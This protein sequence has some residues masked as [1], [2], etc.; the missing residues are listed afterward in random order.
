MPATAIEDRNDSNGGGTVSV[1]RRK[2]SRARPMYFPKTAPCSH[3]CPNHIDIR[4]VLTTMSERD[5]DGR[6]VDESLEAAWRIYT[7]KS[8]FPAI[9]GRV[10][11]HPCEDECNRAQRDESVGI[12]NV[13]RFIGDY[14]IEKGLEFDRIT[15]ESRAEKIAV[16]GSGP[17]G[18]SCAYQLTRRGY[19]VTVYEALDQPGGM[20][21]YGIPCY[22]LSREVLDAEYGRLQ[23]FGIEIKCSAGVGKE[24][25]HEDLI[26]QYNSI[27]LGIGAHNGRRLAIPGE[28]LSNI[29]TGVDF[30]NRINRGEKIDVGGQVVVIGGGNTA[31]D[32]ARVSRRLGAKSTILYR[33][34]RAE[35]PAIA[36]EIIYA[37][38]EGVELRLLA[39]PVE[40]VEEADTEVTLKCI[41][42]ELGEPDSSGRRRPIP[43][44]GSYFHLRASTVIAAISQEPE[45]DGFWGLLYGRDWI[46]INDNG[47]TSFEK[48]YAG[49]DVSRIGLA[50]DAVYQGRMAA[51]SI[52]AKL[53]GT[54]VFG[55]DVLPVI[56]AEEMTLSYYPEKPRNHSAAIPVEERL[57][58][59]ETE[60][61][62]TISGEQALDEVDRCMSCGYCSRCGRCEEVCE[63]G[64][65]I[66]PKEAGEYYRFKIENCNG[67]EE[68][69]RECP[70][71]FIEMREERSNYKW[72][73][74]LTQVGIGVFLTNG[75]FKV[76]WT[77]EIYD[78]PLKS[79]CVP[80]LNCHACPMAQLSCPI[81]MI[82]YYAAVHQ[83][84]Y[85]VLGFLALIGI[86]FGRAACG[87][88][89]P[90][91]WFQDMMYKIKTRKFGIPKF[92]YP[93]KWVILPVLVIALPYITGAHWFSKLCP[94]GALIGGIPWAVWNPTHPVFEE[95]IIEP[96]SFGLMFWVKIV[97]LGG[98]L[99]WFVLA[100]RPF[101]RTVCPLG[102]IFSIFNRISLLKLEVQ[103]DCPGCATCK[104]MCPMDLD[105]RKEVESE[106]CIKC[107]DCTACDQVKA[108][109]TMRYGFTKLGR[110]MK[111]ARLKFEC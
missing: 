24:I 35:M 44:E 37:E 41:R 68:C 59:P 111:A 18:M 48:I 52:D 28:D 75:F 73:R 5:K 107:L 88:T 12:K 84:P 95:P 109:F 74:R 34:T 10:C 8:P 87:W 105:V 64:A 110:M 9:L 80:G 67:C 83:F 100:K 90:F 97:I 2:T 55:E 30:L 29:Y 45:F 78:G 4:E 17:A 66:E 108:K 76:W 22:R 42:M 65:V 106:N 86:L 25:Y 11:P 62:A 32:A 36:E 91:G 60:I 51:L 101:C 77:K 63:E 27:F 56:N 33:R 99:V 85:M 89:C 79:F 16:V 46:R 93:L 21:R 81:G 3:A 53:R 31:I 98:F 69:A 26:E 58:H 13:E 38:E 54:P 71:G 39:A 103:A 72:Y 20:L 1:V 61:R 19:R 82:Q 6:S 15:G 96:G 47:Q 50:V 57:A 70:T 40:I 7:E 94:Y 92:L 104:S 102:A 14:A 43:I 49:G 23:D